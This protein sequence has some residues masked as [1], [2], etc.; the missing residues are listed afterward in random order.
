MTTSMIRPVPAISAA[1]SSIPSAATSLESDVHSI[2]TLKKLPRPF[3]RKTWA[4][5]DLLG[6]LSSLR[7][8]SLLS[9]SSTSRAGPSLLSAVSSATSGVLPSASSAVRSLAP[10]F[11]IP[12]SVVSSVVSSSNLPTSLPTSLP[13]IRTTLRITNTIPI[14][15]STTTV[16]V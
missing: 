8:A 12:N 9:S 13:T 11:A 15:T 7:T 5:D 1:A 10:M 16:L 6:E 14:A 2:S 4:F 3:L